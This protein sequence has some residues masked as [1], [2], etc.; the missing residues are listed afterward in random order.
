MSATISEQAKTCTIELT[1]A[2]SDVDLPDNRTLRVIT[3]RGGGHAFIQLRRGTPSG[4]V[5]LIGSIMLDADDARKLFAWLGTRI[6]SGDI[7]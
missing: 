1:A 2:P 6:H 5:H 4:G 7:S 3:R